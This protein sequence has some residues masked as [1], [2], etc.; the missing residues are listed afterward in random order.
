MMLSSRSVGL[1]ALSAASALRLPAAP[2]LSRRAFG[3]G[4]AAAA[5]A[6]PAA[7]RADSGSPTTYFEDAA[8]G[9]SVSYPTAW[10]QIAPGFLSAPGELFSVAEIGSAS[11][12]SVITERGCDLAKY[13]ADT[14]CAVRITAP[15]ASRLSRFGEADKVASGLMV[16][17]DERMAA[18]EGTTTARSVT[19]QPDGSLVIDA[20]TS[21]P[22]GAKKPGAF[23][24]APAH[25]RHRR[26]VAAVASSP[27]SHG[28][29][30][31]RG[32]RR[33]ARP[34][35]PTPSPLPPQTAWASKNRCT[36]AERSA[37]GR[38]LSA[39]RCCRC[40]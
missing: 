39:T 9:F 23:R 14:T 34:A 28:R 22:T 21:I 4:A 3:I 26:I 2:P 16:R 8:S 5:A 17:H 25:R 31:T 11:V 30:A 27:P 37:L 32:A 38:T 36:F 40:G 35:S 7:A 10:R 20:Y 15:S 6:A 29:S 13:A 18:L 24:A 19:V 1:L 33:P 12:V